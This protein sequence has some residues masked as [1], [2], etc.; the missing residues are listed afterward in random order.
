M[1]A[2]VL[3]A[4]VLGGSA[5]ALTASAATTTNPDESLASKIAA[6]FNIN[7]DEVQTVIKE[8][9]DEHRAEHQAERQQRL[10]ERLTTAVSEGKLTEDQK[11]KILEFVKTQEANF[12]NLKDQTEDER[13]A[14][15]D[16][17]REEVKKWAADNGID[18]KYLMPGGGERGPG[19][20]R[21]DSD[22]Q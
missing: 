16:A 20:P 11:A 5:F 6:K 14:S 13:K 21:G 17:H 18:E 1:S 10:E 4:A 15:M 12:E 19:G 3:S 8:Y 9:R 7:K 22:T 2:G